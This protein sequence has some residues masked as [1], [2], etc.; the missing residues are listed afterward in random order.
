MSTARIAIPFTGDRW[1]VVP[2][3]RECSRD[4]KCEVHALCIGCAEPLPIS[5]NHS[6]ESSNMDDHER[7]IAYLKADIDKA[8]AVVRAICAQT[9]VS[10]AEF[11]VAKAARAKAAETASAP[12]PGQFNP[13]LFASPEVHAKFLPHD[14]AA[15]DD[16]DGI[17]S[18]DDADSAWGHAK[19]AM[20]HI[21]QCCDANS[22][23]CDRAPADG[24]PDHL[25]LAAKHIQEA[26]QMRERGGRRDLISEN[27]HHNRVRF[28]THT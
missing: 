23:L 25:V 13:Q 16:D 15:F 2:H 3:V 5:I 11:A 22:E 26:M 9:G 19:K 27:S 6:R 20:N 21:E 12:K 1:A 7:K 17:P 28:E 24:S 4:G 14:D 18:A 8:D 10:E